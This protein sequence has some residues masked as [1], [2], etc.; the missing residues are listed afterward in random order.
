MT[1]YTAI[2]TI[3]DYLLYNVTFTVTLLLKFIFILEDI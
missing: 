3:F 2:A 1:T